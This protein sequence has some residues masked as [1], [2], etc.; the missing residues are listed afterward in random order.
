M[1]RHLLKT[2][3]I[4]NKSKHDAVLTRALS[5][6]FSKRHNEYTSLR[7]LASNDGTLLAT[8]NCDALRH[9]GSCNS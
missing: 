1:L 9:L 5:E 4:A 7:I 2:S 6:T 3:E 8:K